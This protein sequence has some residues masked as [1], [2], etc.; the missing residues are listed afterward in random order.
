MIFDINSDFGNLYYSYYNGNSYAEGMYPIA[1]TND[2]SNGYTRVVVTRTTTTNCIAVVIGHHDVTSVDKYL[3]VKN[4]MI[5]EGDLTQTPELIPT[6]Y[7]EGLKSSFEDNVVTQAM[8]DSGEESSENLGKYKVEYKVTGKNKFD[9]SNTQRDLG[10]I[11]Y[12]YKDNMIYING[13]TTENYQNSNYVDLYLVP[14]KSYTLSFATDNTDKKLAYPVVSYYDGNGNIKYIT[15][16]TNNKFTWK[17][18][19]THPKNIF[20]NR[21]QRLCV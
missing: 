17:K 16:H 2:Y 20:T 15:N 21:Q 12:T 7:V 11:T 13:T 19:Y 9:M 4:L 18:H 5:F 8:V 6:E 1:D 3:N 10:N 14:E